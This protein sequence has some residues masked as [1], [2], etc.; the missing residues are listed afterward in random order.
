MAI[1]GMAAEG[2]GDQGKLPL[3]RRPEWKRGPGGARG[4][5]VIVA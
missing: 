5:N 1:C 4:S 2:T 3:V